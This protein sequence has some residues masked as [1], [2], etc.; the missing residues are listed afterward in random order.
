MVREAVTAYYKIKTKQ[1]KSRA[2]QNLPKLECDIPE[3]AEDL[4]KEII[5]GMLDD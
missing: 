1:E 4:E 5:G 3:N 2:L